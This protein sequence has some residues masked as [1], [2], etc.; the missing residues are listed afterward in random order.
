MF[1]LYSIIFFL[2]FQISFSTTICA[3]NSQC[4]SGSCKG[5]Y[6]CKINDP[7]CKRCN[8]DGDCNGCELG[9]SYINGNC[10]SVGLPGNKCDKN[11]DCM[12]LKCG[13]NGFCCNKKNSADVNCLSCDG[14]IDVIPYL[15]TGGTCFACN[16]TNTYQTVMR[17]CA[18]F[19]K[20][21]DNCYYNY[22]ECGNNAYCLN[23]KCT[24]IP[25]E[26]KKKK[27]HRRRRHRKN[28]FR[29]LVI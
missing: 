27:H 25:V 29:D 18:Y 22:L 11:E 14:N 6:C 23:T 28:I 10:V 7:K 12:Y 24:E 17:E 20:I 2:T 19:K 3:L 8:I 15:K 4:E 26:K 9:Y 16:N 1:L 5:N 21:G 13:H